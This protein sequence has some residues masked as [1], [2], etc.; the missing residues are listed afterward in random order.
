MVIGGA[1]IYAQLID[2]AQR[3]FLTLVQEDV[4]GD[5]LFPEIDVEQWQIVSDELH[6]AD[7]RHA[8]DYRFVNYQRRAPAR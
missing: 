3:M 4:V 5:A 8:F 1:Q 6:S 7:E 2:Q